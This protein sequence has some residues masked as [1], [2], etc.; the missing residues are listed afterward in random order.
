MNDHIPSIAVQISRVPRDV[1]LFSFV[2]VGFKTR[3]EKA[4]G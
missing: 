3:D 1:E 4:V 2:G